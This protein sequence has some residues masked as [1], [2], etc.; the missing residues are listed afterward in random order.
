MLGA[1]GWTITDRGRTADTKPKELLS[2][3]DAAGV[4]QRV[5]V[6]MRTIMA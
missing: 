2:Y 4:E 3:V 1:T 6:E 5:V